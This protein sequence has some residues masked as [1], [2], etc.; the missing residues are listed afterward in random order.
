MF[1]HTAAAFYPKFFSHDFALMTQHH[2]YLISDS[3]GETVHSIARACAV[4]FENVEVIEHVWP[5]VR[6]PKALETVMEDINAEPG[7]VLFTLLDE[8]MRR[9][10]QD[11][12]RATNVTCISVLDPF[13]GA[14]GQYFGAVSRGQ[15]GRQHVMDQEYFSRIDAINFVMAHDDGQSLS[16]LAE[17][18]IILVGV[19]RTSKT[20]T[21]I[22]LANRGVKAANVPL[23]PDV[24]LPG[25]LF[26]ATDTLVVGLTEDPARLVQIRRNR[27]RLLNKG[28]ET[29]Y[30]DLANVKKEVAEARRL[31]NEKGWPII[32]VT[33]RSI[34]ETAAAI[35][36][37]YN[38]R[39]RDAVG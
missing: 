35:L 18:E 12:C 38:Q 26:E 11:F 28:S 24:P 20:P 30:T 4:Q 14:M 16:N 36:Q 17:A 32:D 39:Q 7:L 23:V 1:V 33:R 22:Y 21:C 10:L 3:T 34:E 19:S 15:P 6:T 2:L 37:L 29:P 8:S 25:E 27:L 13:I 9:V 5:M 31:F